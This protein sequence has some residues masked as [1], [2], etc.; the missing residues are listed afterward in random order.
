M[1]PNATLKRIAELLEKSEVKDSS[2][3]QQA[4]N[5]SREDRRELR[6]ACHNLNAWLGNGGFA[7]RWNDHPEAFE[8]FR[9]WQNVNG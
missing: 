9:S 1:D 6:E 7:P 2:F 8:F 4:A 5:L 3:W